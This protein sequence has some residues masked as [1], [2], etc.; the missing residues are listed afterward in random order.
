[1]GENSSVSLIR[2]QNFSVKLRL[3]TLIVVFQEG[4]KDT[5][6][7]RLKQWMR[8]PNLLC[9]SFSFAIQP[10]WKLLSIVQ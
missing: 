4:I 10:D 3:L 1:M 5:L 7:F 9:Q 2:N 6:C 8:N